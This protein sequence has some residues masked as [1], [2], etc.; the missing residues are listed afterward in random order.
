LYPF[1]REV[2]PEYAVISVG[3]GNSYGHPHEN[4]L[5]RLRDAGAAVYRTD[6]QGTIICVSDGKTVSFQPEKNS[7]A[8][9][10]PTAAPG[11][12]ENPAP[13]S[14]SPDRAL[15][16]D[17]AYIGNANTEKFHLPVCRSLPDEKNRVFF[18]TREGAVEAGYSPCGICKP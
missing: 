6:L 11:E 12:T 2:M 1:L 17:A 8:P 15:S 9:T 10:N 7:A 16:S 13:A 4:T 18:A 14:E 3:A 5:S